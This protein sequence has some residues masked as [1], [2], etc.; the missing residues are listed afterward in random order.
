MSRDKYLKIFECILI[1]IAVWL[2][3]SG[4]VNIASTLN[5]EKLYKNGQEVE[6]FVDKYYTLSSGSGS[7]RGYKVYFVCKYV[8]STTGEIYTAETVTQHRYPPDKA[9]EI[10]GKYV[11]EKVELVI[12]GSLCAAKR[13]VKKNYVS[14]V[15]ITVFFTV[16]GA[17]G[18]TACIV[19]ETVKAKRK[20]KK[21]VENSGDSCIV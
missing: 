9:E 8:Q 15:L 4:F 18:I 12:S 2:F 6:G 16:G 3:I 20:K 21:D 7:A 11:G 19:I 10:G 1:V 5:A 17:L 13:D 14:S